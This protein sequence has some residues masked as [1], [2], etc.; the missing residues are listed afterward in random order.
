MAVFNTIT[1]GG[2]TFYRPNDFEP[3]REYVYAAEYTTLDGAVRADLVGWKYSDLELKWDMLPDAMK[4]AL[5]SLNGQTVTM[6]FTDADGPTASEQII[7]LTHTMTA[8]RMKKGSSPVWKDVETEVRFLN[9][10]SS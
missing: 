5:L 10:H 8:T 3:A 2:T 6:T 4:N 9:V 7:P 1:I